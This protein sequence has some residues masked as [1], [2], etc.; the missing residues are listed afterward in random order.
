LYKPS[1][2]LQPILALRL[3]DYIE[4][5]AGCPRDQT[6]A[7][8]G[9]GNDGYRAPDD[10]KE[11]FYY[12]NGK[13]EFDCDVEYEF[14]VFFHEAAAVKWYE[15]RTPDIGIKQNVRFLPQ[16]TSRTA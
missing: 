14:H 15:S 3:P 13:G 5:L 2:D 1:C 16:E 10:Q 12:R 6:I 8:D 4:T 7:K 9:L 11:F